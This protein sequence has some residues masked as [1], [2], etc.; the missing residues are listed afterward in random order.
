MELLDLDEGL[1]S[2]ACGG[3]VLSCHEQLFLESGLRALRDQEGFKEIFFWGKIFAMSRDYYVAYGETPSGFEMPI[4]VFYYATEDFQF[5]PLEENEIHELTASGITEASCDGEELVRVLVPARLDLAVTAASDTAGAVVALQKKGLSTLQRWRLARHPEIPTKVRLETPSGLVLSVADATAAALK[6]NDP[7]DESLWWDIEDGLL[8]ISSG[9]EP[10]VVRLVL[11]A[12]DAVEPGSE[13]VV[14]PHDP[15]AA[16]GAQ[17]RWAL[18]L[19]SAARRKTPLARPPEDVEE[20]RRQSGTR[21]PQGFTGDPAAILD[22]S[23][24]DDGTAAPEEIPDETD[25][26]AAPPAPPPKKFTELDRLALTVREI[27]FD[28][29]VVPKG[30]YTLNEAHEVVLSPSFRGLGLTEAKAISAY[31]HLRAPATISGQ[32]ALARV[33][34]E[35]FPDF[36][37]P[38][39]GDI[40]RGCWSIRA[41]TNAALVTLRSLSWQGYI[42]YIAPGTTRFGGAYFGYGLKNLELPFLL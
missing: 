24:P 29:S 1:R 37:D 18:A 41:D 20:L 16:A 14:K 40:P 30:A 21:A 26:T 9:A 3:N 4:K 5:T 34:A 22:S 39:A 2:I 10:D 27:D 31:A 7:E 8:S 12:S 38:L 36:L 32:R 6:A 11:Q 23:T 33:D 35:F 19:G 13:L 25:A 17:P 42:A 15:A 28:T